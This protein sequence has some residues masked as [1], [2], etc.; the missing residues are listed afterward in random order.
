MCEFPSRHFLAKITSLEPMSVITECLEKVWFSSTCATVNLFLLVD[1]EK[2]NLRMSR[3]TSLENLNT[4]NILM[5]ER[6]FVYRS[7]IFILSS[8]CRVYW[9][10]IQPTKESVDVGAVSL[11]H[12]VRVKVNTKCNVRPI[13][14]CNGSSGR[15]VGDCFTCRS[16]SDSWREV[17]STCS[18]S[19][20][21]LLGR[22]LAL[23]RGICSFQALFN[24]R[25]QR[26]DVEWGRRKKARRRQVQLEKWLACPGWS[27]ASILNSFRKQ[28]ECRKMVT[29]S[30]GEKYLF[31]RDFFIAHS[32]ER[33]QTETT[34]NE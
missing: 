29:T 24:A 3:C 1:D 32:R 16:I 9:V 15:L 26:G 22:V 11:V 31:N 8:I 25:A 10:L 21:L 19:R 6:A 27:L 4:A 30:N 23:D 5:C 14:K 18:S 34:R 2:F 33:D 20:C 13:G 7:G 12:R 28:L 17:K